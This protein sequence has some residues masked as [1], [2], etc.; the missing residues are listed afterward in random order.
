MRGKIAAALLLTAVAVARTTAEH[1]KCDGTKDG[2]IEARA[3][4][5]TFEGRDLAEA[6][7]KAT[8]CFAR[9]KAGDHTGCAAVY[10]VTNDNVFGNANVFL[11]MAS[12]RQL[13]QP[14]PPLTAPHSTSHGSR[15]VRVCEGSADLGKPEHERQTDTHVGGAVRMVQR[16]TVPEGKREIGDVVDE[17]KVQSGGGEKQGPLH[18]HAHTR[19]RDASSGMRGQLSSCSA[20]GSVQD[21]TACWACVMCVC[22]CVCGGRLAGRW[23]RRA[24]P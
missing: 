1:R 20:T 11:E 4:P 21:T 24:V 22:V 9:S 14:A 7:K 17:E 3:I 16:E 12:P 18:A 8:A 6:T 23:L 5:E 2:L 13:C 19:A 15:D 10:V